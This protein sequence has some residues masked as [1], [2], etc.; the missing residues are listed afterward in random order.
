M[1]NPNKPRGLTE[2]QRAAYD[3]RKA[4]STYEE[5][6]VALGCKAQTARTFCV[7]AEKNG[8]APLP[9][10][11]QL[12][13][14][15][16]GAAAKADGGFDLAGFDKLAKSMGV[17]ARVAQALARR[18]VAGMGMMK[19]EAKRMSLAEEIGKVTDIKQMILEYADPVAIAAAG[20]KDLTIAYGVLTDKALLLGGK[21]NVIVD[22]NMRRQLAELMPAMLAEAKRRG[23]T[24]DATAT[25][26][27]EKVLLPES[28][29]ASARP[30]ESAAAANPIV[31]DGKGVH[32]DTKYQ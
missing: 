7:Q 19:A 5:I 20:L 11:G 31:G 12:Q 23:L 4:G 30:V 27:Q 25:I 18:I 14:L 10:R 13:A 15:A 32:L 2:R 3:M 1:T 22:F 24:I 16:S 29:D 9:R 21:P 26:I 17:P 28:D 6:G 8:L